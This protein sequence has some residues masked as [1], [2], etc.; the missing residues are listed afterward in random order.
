MVEVNFRCYF[1]GM[2]FFDHYR[3]IS[4]DEI[5]EWIRCYRF[6]HP[7]CVSVSVKI[8]FEKI[9]RLSMDAD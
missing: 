5:S 4:L 8:W 2:V 1:P 9:E 7:D 6:T 3:K